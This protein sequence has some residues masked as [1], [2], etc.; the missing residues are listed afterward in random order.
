[1][2]HGD[3]IAMLQS[4]WHEERLLALLLLVGAYDRGAA[5]LRQQIYELYLANTERINSWDLVDASAEHIVGR[6]IRGGD[7]SVLDRLAASR[8]VWER[9]IAIMAT[10]RF[11]K[12]NDPAE[13]FRVAGLLLQ[14]EHPLMHKAT[15]WMLRE[16]GKRD[17]AALD[18]FLLSSYRRMPRP[19]LRHA[20]QRLAPA[21]RIEFLRGLA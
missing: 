20:I 15:G 7:T 16:A 10:F 18:A 14:D 17:P 12:E 1:M 11:I 6:H 13:T 9:R 19:M 21:R 4:P 2:S 3:C 8:I 5:A